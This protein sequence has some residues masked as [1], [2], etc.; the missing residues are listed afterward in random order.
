MSPIV[1]MMKLTDLQVSKSLKTKKEM[2]YFFKFQV[3]F[4][5]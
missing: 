2:S 5:D 3:M 1:Y 4:N